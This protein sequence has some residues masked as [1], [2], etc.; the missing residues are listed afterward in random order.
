MDSG[1][2]T[3]SA[4]Y[5]VRKTTPDSFLKT[6]LE[7]VLVESGS[8]HL[9]VCGYATEFCI[10][11]T[12]RRAA[13]LG[14]DVTV[15]SDAHTTHDKAH[16][17]AAQIIAHHNATLPSIKSFGVHILAQESDAVEFVHV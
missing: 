8:S 12:V 6:D 14:Y 7:S 4:D 13:A 11:T 15:V 17:D 2:L 9:V 10:D 16:A 1:L 3:G 5:F